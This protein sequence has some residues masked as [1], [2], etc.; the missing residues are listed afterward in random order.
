MGSGRDDAPYDSGASVMSWDGNGG[1]YKWRV[2]ATPAIVAANLG[3]GQKRIAAPTA[4]H[5]YH[6][7]CSVHTPYEVGTLGHLRYVSN[8]GRWGRIEFE[9]GVAP[10]S[11]PEDSP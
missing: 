8:S 3:D 5:D 9:L 10:E 1:T 7:L 11:A 6:R 4:E 2:I